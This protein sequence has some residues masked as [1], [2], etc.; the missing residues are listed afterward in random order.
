MKKNKF[1]IFSPLDVTILIKC[2]PSEGVL[3][4][5]WFLSFRTI[6]KNRSWI[7]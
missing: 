5:Y 7:C 3:H 6:K 4:E 2:S 1:T